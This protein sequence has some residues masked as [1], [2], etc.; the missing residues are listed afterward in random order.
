MITP[1]KDWFNFE[2]L[3]LKKLNGYE[4]INYLLKTD[5]GKFIFKTY[6]YSEDMMAL[7]EAENSVLNALENENTFPQPIVFKDGSFLKIADL[8][9]TKTICRVL[10]FLDG[11]FLGDVKHTPSLIESIGAFAAQLNLQLLKLNNYVLKA[12]QW[13]WDLQYLQLNKKYIQDIEEASDRHLVSYFFQQYELHV[14]PKLPE[15]RKSIIHNDVNEWNTL[16][17]NNT[18]SG[19]ID[20]G[21][22]AHSPLINE[23]AIAITYACYDKDEPL[24]WAIH[25]VKGYHKVLPLEEKELDILYY[26][27]AGRLCTS[28]CNAAHSKKINPENVYASSSEKNA[29][30]MLHHWITINPI[31]A[32]NEFYKAANF[33]IET[34]I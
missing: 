32:K 30:K 7:I 24:E 19:L 1:I 23:L 28:L 21:D 5:N 15:L 4:N 12:R 8:N 18:V 29:L 9:N 27:I 10:T 16:I 6:K 11:D 14:A 13:E 34:P 20:F 26:L 2:I 31:K 22:L 17:K 33:S 3:E 25:L